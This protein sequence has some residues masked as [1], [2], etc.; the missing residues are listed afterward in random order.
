VLL[1]ASAVFIGHPGWAQ[2]PTPVPAVPLDPADL[3]LDA[4]Q[5]HFLVAL[6]EPHR[7]E[8]AHAMRLALIRDRRIAHAIDDIVVEF[9]SARYQDIIDR[10]VRGEQVPNDILRQVWQNTTQGHTV[11][12]VPIYEEFFRAVRVV[13]GS[14]ARGEQIRV[15]LG[16]P[17][18]DWENVRGWQDVARPMADDNRDRFPA[19][20]IRREVLTKRRRALIIYGDGHLWR[21]AG[22]P[23]LAS[24]LR[25]DAGSGLFTIASSTLTDLE[26][27]QPDVASW[28]APR[29]ARVHGTVL[30]VKKFQHYFPVLPGD[31]DRWHS[32]RLQDQFD[33]IAYYGPRKA[34][35][36]SEVP[37]SLC[38]DP[39]Y[40]KMRLGRLVWVPPGAPNLAER[41]KQHCAKVVPK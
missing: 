30:G 3:V 13:N 28:R 24:L 40:M 17:P 9:G 31:P 8:Q 2:Q 23:T 25:S 34:L 39:V 6:G 16:D 15:L 22:F 14:I 7:N 36:Y 4:F 18:T 11:W 26:A 35:T 33:A 19:E 29:I 27:V 1:V 38:S 20:L 41:L 5:S 10:F 21:D 12:D 37:P 32:V